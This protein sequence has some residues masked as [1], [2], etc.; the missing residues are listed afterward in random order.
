M[1][2]IPT[3]KS[4]VEM[5]D[6]AFI[7]TELD[8]GGRQNQLVRLAIQ[9][10]TLGWNVRMISMLPPQA[11]THELESAQIPVVS[12]DM[13]RGQPS[14]Q[15]F[16]QAVSIL[17]RW[18]PQILHSHLV[19]ANLLARLV[20]PFASVPVLISTAGNIKEGGR[21]RELAY[22]LTDPLCDLTTNVSQ[23]AT[24]RYVEIGAVPAD[25][26]LFIANSIDT[27]RF[28][29]NLSSRHAIRHELHLEDQFVWLAVGRLEEQKDYPNMLEA[30][31]QVASLF[32]NAKL[33]ICGKGA[34]QEKIEICIERLNLQKQVKL[35][36]IRKDIPDL[37]NAADAYVMSSAWE[38]MPSVLL[39]ASAVGLPIVAT[40]TSGN[41]EIAI[42]D[43]NA[44][45]VPTQNS[46]A[47]AEAMKSL[48]KLSQEERNHMGEIGRQLIVSNYS[49]ETKLE[50]WI[51]LYQNMLNESQT[52][53]VD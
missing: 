29:P 46:E 32:P 43:R 10:K 42:D 38:G 14:I 31:S 41:R 13:R 5:I 1:T 19:H 6:I 23:A 34:L 24:E 3:R 26:I 21:W 11:F 48:M 53:K 8:Y 39:E 15:G 52:K 22:R 7:I 45:L 2:Q 50:T 35:L 17:R 28:A 16:C 18:K 30:F 47:L 12:L 51:S 37:M 33:L 44:F 9:L 40:D 25:K 49:S 36:G 27:N 4:S 20:R